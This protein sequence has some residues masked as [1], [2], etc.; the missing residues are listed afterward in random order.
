[1]KPLFAW[2]DERLVPTSSV[3]VPADDPG[4]LVGDALFETMRASEGRVVRLDAHLARLEASRLALAMPAPPVDPRV[5]IRALLDAHPPSSS[6]VVVRLTLSARPTL[7][8]QLRP[9]AHR[10]LVRRAGLALW[11]LPVRRGESF[12]ARHKS[13]A[14]ASNAIQRRLHHA[15]TAD[16]FEGLWLDPEGRVLEGTSTNLFAVIDGAVWTPPLSHPILAGTA[17]AAAIAALVGASV[18]VR[19]APL[20]LDAFAAAEALFATNATLPVAPI[21]SLDGQIRGDAADALV[22]RLV[23]ALD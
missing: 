13:A 9:L 6:D 8:V 5:A 4:W 11:T 23:A 17:R 15:G 3:A 22:R 12:L 16:A 19:E 7:V 20:T 1:M 10:E 21:L 14:W 18:E 2:L